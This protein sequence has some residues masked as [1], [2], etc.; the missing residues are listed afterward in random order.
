MSSGGIFQIITNTGAQDK[1]LYAQEYLK[2]R[3]DKFIQDK[4]PNITDND[5]LSLPDNDKYLNIKNSILPSLNEIERSHSTFVNGSYK[6]CIA[7]ASEYLKVGYSAPKFDSKLIFQIPQ[8]GQFTSD[9]VLHIR[10][11]GLAAKD[12]RDRVRYTSL[13]GHKLIKNVQFTVNN[14][15]IVDEYT[16][17]DM[18]AYLQYEV[19]ENHKEGYLRNIGQEIPHVG[20]STSDP[21][22]DMHREYKLVGDGNQTLKQSHEPIDLYIPILFWFKDLKNALP[23]FPFGKLQIQ[24]QLAKIIDIVGF[25]AMGGDGSYTPPIIEFCDM[26]VNQ[27]FTAPE[28]FNLYSKKFVFSLIK[29]HRQHKEAIK[30]N[31]DQNYQALLNNLK[32]PTESL[33]FS[34]RPRENLKLSQYWHK[35]CKLIEKSYKIP[36]VAKDPNSSIFGTCAGNSTSNT[37]Q[38]VF[39]G[40]LSTNNS[41]AGYDLV[42]MSGSGYNPDIM[43]NRYNIS[44]YVGSTN[45]AT[46][47]GVWDNIVPDATTQFELYNSQLAIN[48]VSYFKEVPIVSNIALTAN[49]IE[50]YRNHSEGFYNSYLPS[51]YKNMNIPDIGSYMMT[52]AL[53]PGKH[54]PSGSINV[55]LCRELYLRY[56]SS[57]I[58]PNYPVDLIVL[59]RAI[60]FL[61]VDGT[62]LT[63]RYSI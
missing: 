58:T 8:I 21:L 17:D 52:F 57:V 49:G 44:S 23:S 3:I 60:N 11:S 50:I 31:Q 43:K 32:W 54:N 47:I 55:S 9:C 63:L 51:K 35:N 2:N 45:I 19:P 20:Y 53:T 5:L 41:Y 33:F 6:P 10:L 13:L 34:F 61:L 39:N 36:V 14:G 26:Y 30:V 22:M 42:I 38:L 1:M 12:T 25:S 7:I 40:V 62:S 56:T 46:I 4:D 37:L 15:S 29:V 28:I 16:T 18:N 48:V 59:S 27:L 24:V